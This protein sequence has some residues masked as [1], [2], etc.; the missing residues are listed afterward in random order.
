[1]PSEKL[2]KNSE[3]YYHFNI[4]VHEKQ[5]HHTTIEF[6]PSSSGPK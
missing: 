6:Q 4:S 5:R 2:L 3:A 1:M